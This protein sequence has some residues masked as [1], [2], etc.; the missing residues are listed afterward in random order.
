[1]QFN[2]GLQEKFGLPCASFHK[3]HKCSTLYS[4]PLHQIS[5]KS[6][7]KHRT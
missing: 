7:N 3:T 4:D 2:L 1:M 6:N 5:P